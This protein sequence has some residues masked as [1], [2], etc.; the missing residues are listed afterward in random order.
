MAIKRLDITTGPGPRMSRCV[1]NGDTVYVCGLT[2]SDFS[3]DIKGQ[4]RANPT[5]CTLSSGSRT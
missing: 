1:I 3:L 4:V 2:S 5:C